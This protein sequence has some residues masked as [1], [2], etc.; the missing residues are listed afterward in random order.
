MVFQIIALLVIIVVGAYVFGIGTDFFDDIFA[1]IEAK[2]AAQENKATD[3]E[4]FENANLASQTGTRVCDLNIVFFG[5][6]WEIDP[7]GFDPF[8]FAE[9][10]FVY[11]GDITHP[12]SQLQPAQDTRT[13]RADWLCVGEKTEEQ[14][15]AEASTSSTSTS[16]ATITPSTTTTTPPTTAQPLVAA[17]ST[18]GGEIC[19]TKAR[20]TVV[21]TTLSFLDLFGWNLN[22]NTIDGLEELSLLAFGASLTDRETITIQFIG[23]SLTNQG[24]FLQSPELDKGTPGNPFTK[25]VTLPRGSQFPFAFQTP[26]LNLDDVTEDNYLIEYWIE[27]FRLNAKA[28]GTIFN[29]DL[30]KP[31]LTN[32]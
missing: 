4:T 23:R 22:K 31:G 7:F 1:D 21:C 20:G 14:K 5:T 9:S 18:G 10:R 27:D 6:I 17:G 28:P 8:N 25:S 12:F 16:M 32:C 19:V 13:L 15:Q 3:L 24:K 2:A 30:C 11:I 29:I 26:I